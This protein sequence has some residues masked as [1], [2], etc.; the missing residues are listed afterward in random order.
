MSLTF[1]CKSLMNFPIFCVPATSALVER[2]FSKSGLILRPHRSSMSSALLAMQIYL[3]SNPET[4][5]Q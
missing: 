1:G 4:L 3:K 5:F 2:I